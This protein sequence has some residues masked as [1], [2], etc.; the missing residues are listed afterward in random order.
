MLLSSFFI[1]D[2]EKSGDTL[3]IEV[4]E[5]GH[6]CF[7]ITRS[8][9]D[10]VHSTNKQLLSSHKKNQFC[11]LVNVDEW[12]ADFGQMIN[13]LVPYT[14]FYNY[15]KFDYENPFVILETWQT[16]KEGYV[17]LVKEQFRHHGYND[18]DIMILNRPGSTLSPV[19]KSN[20]F[21]FRKDDE[22]FRSAYINKMIQISSANSFMYFSLND[23]GDLAPL[24]KLIEETDT[25]ILKQFPQLYHLLEEQTAAKKKQQ[26]MRFQ[27]G[28]QRERIDSIINYHAFLST[29]DNRYSKQIK[30]LMEF[31]KN[32][33]EIL[34][35]WY[36][37]FG[38][39]IK[40]ITGKRTF[41][42]LFNDNVKKYKD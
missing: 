5:N 24:L 40:V 35:M 13:S 1:I 11:L 17:E 29:A 42:S 12:E 28:V 26:E 22:N 16:G 38:H 19:E 14:F 37:R 3:K 30:E 27:I 20:W 15:L 31:Y 33:Y 25:L 10:R 32:E 36:K 41:K 7:R 18:V 39:V 21:D 8:F 9:T 6:L 34:P 23:A 2:F 4:P